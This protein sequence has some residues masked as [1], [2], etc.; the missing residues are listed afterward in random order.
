V[1]KT[2]ITA[3][4][5]HD[6]HA[7]DALTDDDGTAAKWVTDVKSIK[8]LKITSVLDEDPTT[9]GYPAGTQLKDVSVT[10]HVAWNHDDASVGSGETEWGYVL[11][12][13]QKTGWIIVDQG[14]G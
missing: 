6:G 2:Y 3:L 4:N 7:V 1:I 13:S 14:T 9:A 5:A 12:Q 11:K 10:F 8:D